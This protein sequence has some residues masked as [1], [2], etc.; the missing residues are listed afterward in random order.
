MSDLQQFLDALFKPGDGLIEI[1]A[2]PSKDRAFV[3]PDHLRRVLQFAKSHRHE[4]V[5]FGVAARKD[6]TSG[7]LKNC[8]VIRA[9]F[10]D[11]DFKDTPE[12]KAQRALDAF[13]L[14]FSFL[15]N[16]GG[17]FHCYW[18]LKEPFV[19]VPPA[20]EFKTLLRSM[21]RTL[22]AD[23]SSAEPAHILR[24]PGTLNHKKEYGQPREVHLV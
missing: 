15:I 10:A 12:D 13:P 17:G 22:G 9:V 11:I 24:L 5:Y 14:R 21:A 16:S 19:I 8:S 4:N 3:K 23:L 7:E 18:V 1:R 6:S 2:L 20:E